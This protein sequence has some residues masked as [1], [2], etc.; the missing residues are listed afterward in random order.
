M[1]DEIQAVLEQAKEFGID[2]S[3][4]I[5]TSKIDVKE[6][7]KAM[8]DFCPNC[9]KNCGRG[10]ELWRVRA[11]LKEFS[12]AA[13]IVG[14]EQENFA[15]KILTIEKAFRDRGY[16]KALAFLN[17]PCS[18]ALEEKRPLMKC[19]GIDIISTVRRFKKN[20]PAD[21]SVPYALVLVE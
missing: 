1:G 9:G 11:V 21:L 8:C 2:E 14:K 20:A 6:S 18:S 10:L 17:L 7:V 15:D 13:L 19:S 16:Y 5:Y 12:K 3:M 4:I